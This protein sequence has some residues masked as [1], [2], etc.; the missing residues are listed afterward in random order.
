MNLKLALLGVVFLSACSSA[1]AKP[2]MDPSVEKLP[3]LGGMEAYRFHLPN[4]LKVV[5]LPDHS[6]PTFAYQTWFSV[7]SKDEE[8]GRTGLAHFF[9]HLMFKRTKNTQDGEF[10]RVLDRAGSRGLNAFTAQDYTA[11]IVQLPKS[12]FDLIARLESDRMRNLLVDEAAFKTEREVVKNERRFRTENS[13]DGTLYEELFKLAFKRH[14]YHWPV[15]G[16][17][18]DLD[19]M[20]AADARAFYEKF[21][22]P[23]NATIAIVGDLELNDVRAK[24]G[25]FYASIPAR[26]TE[27]RKYDWD[28]EPTSPRRNRLKLSLSV[29]KLMLAYP[30]PRL[31]DPETPAF[32]MLQAILTDGRGSRLRR[33][34]IDRGIAAEVTS[35]SWM[36]DHPGIFVIEVTLQKDHAPAEAERVI[37]SELERLARAAPGEEEWE[38]ARNSVRFHFYERLEGHYQKAEFIGKTEAVTGDFRN[39]FSLFDKITAL[40]REKLSSSVKRWF[41]PHRRIAI[42][43]MPK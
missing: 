22:N 11:Y 29:P 27:R 8:E 20:E 14:P 24:I 23:A 32:E 28:P 9:E 5:F 42:E 2:E 12:R 34:L 15:I 21:Y 3:F 31:S 30:M 7:G 16:W 19:S 41:A 18:R 43:G 35:G 13:P 33:A 39:G 10:M 40:P 17:E 6:S 1:P 4:G 37:L 38:R 25:E 36:M 26:P